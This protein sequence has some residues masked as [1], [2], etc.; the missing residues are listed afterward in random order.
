MAITI[1]GGSAVFTYN[2][3]GDTTTFGVQ[4]WSVDGGQVEQI[5]TTGSLSTQRTF[6]PGFKG[7][8]EITVEAHIDDTTTTTDTKL[9]TAAIAAWETGR[10]NCASRNLKLKVDDCNADPAG[11][12]DLFSLDVHFIGAS[13]SA[14]LDGVIAV[15]L[16]FRVA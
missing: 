14:E 15:T 2:T 12:V 1:N 16:T 3:A 10:D 9:T 7:P 6:I 11:V 4:S 5:D 13:Y 8:Q